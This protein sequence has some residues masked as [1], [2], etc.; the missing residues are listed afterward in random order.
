M[1]PFRL[2]ES[3]RA[4][5][6]AGAE[7]PLRNIMRPTPGSLTAE[8]QQPAITADLPGAWV[9]LVLTA[10]DLTIDGIDYPVLGG[11]QRDAGGDLVGEA[12]VVVD[13]EM[14]EIIR[15]V[16]MWAGA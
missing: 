15:Y 2:S 16:G 12:G 13:D 4:L 9:P 8:A 14:A 1:I 6:F 11:L 3:R 5:D 7:W 10:R